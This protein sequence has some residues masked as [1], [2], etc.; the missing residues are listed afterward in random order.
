[1]RIN[2]T[3]MKPLFALNLIIMSNAPVMDPSFQAAMHVFFLYN[4][5]S[6]TLLSSNFRSNPRV[7][8]DT[9]PWTRSLSHSFLAS[10][11]VIFWILSE[12]RVYYQSFSFYPNHTHHFIVVT[13][14]QL[15][16]A[17]T[18]D[19]QPLQLNVKRRS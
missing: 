16:T 13:I 3:H 8:G 12:E 6:I 9:S 4:H 17:T 15:L 2:C 19:A 7:I 14:E 11:H 1:M 5:T 10:R 18:I